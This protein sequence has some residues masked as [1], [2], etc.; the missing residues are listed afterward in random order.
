MIEE[1]F[2]SADRAITFLAL[3]WAKAFDSIDPKCLVRA[4]QRFGLPDQYIQCI[5]AI[6]SD[7]KFYVAEKGFSSGIHAQH[8]GISQGCPL[9][10]FLFVM[11]MTVLLHDAN[12]KL[13]H[14]HD[15]AL[16]DQLVCHELV[17]ADDTLL[18]EMVGSN[19]QLYMQCIAECGREYGLA[20]NWTKVEQM[21]INCGHID[22]HS[23]DG[24]LITCKRSLRYL[25]AQL[26]ADGHIESE[27]ALKLGRAAQDFKI[28]MRLWNH[29]NVSRKFKHIVFQAC[30][31]QRLLYS[32]ETAWLNKASLRRIDG[33]QCKCLRRIA[34]ISPSHISRVSNKYILQQFQALPISISLLKRQL[35]LYGRIARL[36]DSSILRRCTFQNGSVE[37]NAH[38][39]RRQG[40]PR[41]TWSR[42]V[43]KHAVNIAGTNNL[44]HILLNTHY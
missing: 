32:L 20:L 2:N 18:L 38:A 44:Q 35:L 26:A 15:I 27:I 10:P 19:L 14:S 21:N 5:K 17:Y 1:A 41:N 16:S 25:G 36:P 23:P 13:I 31:I 37:L 39:K 28:L 9:S 8:F 34:K 33:F 30:I 3:D 12:F 6:Y 4:L 43:Q 42:E 29:C 40:R 24:N 7:R 22:L 11:V